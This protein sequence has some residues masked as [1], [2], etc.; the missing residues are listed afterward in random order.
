MSFAKWAFSIKVRKLL[1][2]AFVFRGPN[3]ENPFKNRI[4]KRVVFNHQILNVVPLILGALGSPK[5]IKKLYIFKKID[6]QRRPLKHYRFRA[7]F[8]MDFEPLGAR[9]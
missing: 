3:E 6:V 4:Q 8:R 9:F 5:I 1:D 2:F 7:A